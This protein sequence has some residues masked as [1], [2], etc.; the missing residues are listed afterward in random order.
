MYD[1]SYWMGSRL[2]SLDIGRVCAVF[3]RVHVA[4]HSMRNILY[5]L[6]TPSMILNDL[7]I[8]PSNIGRWY[9][10]CTMTADTQERQSYN[11]A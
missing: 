5:I 6:Y 4:T 10:E 8:K 3:G 7:F 2:I 1:I 11:H 9:Y